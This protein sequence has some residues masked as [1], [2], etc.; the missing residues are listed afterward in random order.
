V[1]TAA[2]RRVSRRCLGRG[3]FEER[4]AAFAFFACRFS[5]SDLLAAVFE[6]FEPPL[7]LLGMV[8]PGSRR[9]GI[10][11]YH[12]RSGTQAPCEHAQ[13]DGQHGFVP[14]RTGQHI[15]AGGIDVDVTFEEADHQLDCAIDEAYRR[16]YGRSSA[17]E[18]I[19]A[20]KAQATT[21]RV[22]RD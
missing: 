13:H 19:T 1:L 7:S 9:A 14:L 11:P 3:Y 8:P 6:F 20:P 5:F 2:N 16:K 4:E 17:V 12:G 18:H 15:A 10:A 21:L 22:I